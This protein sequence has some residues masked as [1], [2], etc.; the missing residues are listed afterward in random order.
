M[1]RVQSPSLTPEFEPLRLVLRRCRPPVAQS[2]AARSRSDFA[3]HLCDYVMPRVPVRQWV[4]TVPFGL[5]FRLAFDPAL[6]GVVLRIFV[7]VVSRWLRRRARAH[8]I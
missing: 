1:L 5:R 4:L 8:G 7:G 2:P 6:A 3:A